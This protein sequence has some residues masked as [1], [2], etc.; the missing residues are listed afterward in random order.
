M[1]LCD[2]CGMRSIG[3]EIIEIKRKFFRVEKKGYICKTCYDNF[4][5]YPNKIVLDLNK[6]KWWYISDPRKFLEN[7][8][9]TFAFSYKQAWNE[10]NPKGRIFVFKTGEKVSYW[11]VIKPGKFRKYFFS[12]TGVSGVAKNPRE[13]LKIRAGG[14]S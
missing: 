7:S 4:Y 13:L 5:A 3:R 14:G 1:K 9:L 12:D 6:E 2:L 10:F 11:W 8:K